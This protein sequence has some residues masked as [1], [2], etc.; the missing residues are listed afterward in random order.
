[1]YARA[2]IHVDMYVRYVCTYVY[3]YVVMCMCLYAYMYATVDHQS[4][5]LKRDMAQLLR[6]D[7]ELGDWCALYRITPLASSTH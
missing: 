2:A 5:A 3:V 1:M 7:T 6:A 4:R